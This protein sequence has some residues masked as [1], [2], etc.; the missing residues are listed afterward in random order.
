MGCQVAVKIP[1]I[2]EAD[3]SDGM[4]AGV[5][6][7]LI[8]IRQINWCLPIDAQ[9]GSMFGVDRYTDRGTFSQNNCP[10]NRLMR[11][12]WHEQDGA[13]LGW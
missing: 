11:R 10:V 4:V 1:W 13:Q 2:L 6:I 12:Y 8:A 9:H 5:H 7:D 3:E